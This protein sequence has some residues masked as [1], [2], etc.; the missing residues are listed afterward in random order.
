MKHALIGGLAALALVVTIAW[1]ASFEQRDA[2]AD[3]GSIAA[4]LD[5]ADV[6]AHRHRSRNGIAVGCTEAMLERR[7]AAH[8]R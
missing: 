8:A 4:C 7:I 6:A 2:T 5:A 3:T 1:A